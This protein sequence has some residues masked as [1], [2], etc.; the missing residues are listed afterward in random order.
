MTRL[1]IKCRFLAKWPVILAME[2]MRGTI[3]AVLKEL[4]T[5]SF[6]GGTVRNLGSLL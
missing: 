6:Q 1:N 5:L 3:S 2:K 4:K